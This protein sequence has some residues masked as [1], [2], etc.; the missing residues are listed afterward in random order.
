MYGCLL[1]NDADHDVIYNRRASAGF[2]IIFRS[3]MTMY[4]G[5]LYWRADCCGFWKLAS[6][7]WTKPRSSSKRRWNGA[8]KSTPSTS[9]ADGVTNVQA[10]TASYVYIGYINNNMSP[11]AVW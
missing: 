3:S 4:S 6:G 10:I 2:V 9:T 5:W 1:V 7:T 8:A 11:A